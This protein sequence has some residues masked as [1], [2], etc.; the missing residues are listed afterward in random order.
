MWESVPVSVGADREE[1][2]ESP[3]AGFTGGCKSPS[4]VAGG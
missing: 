4:V 2:L 1:L 3:A